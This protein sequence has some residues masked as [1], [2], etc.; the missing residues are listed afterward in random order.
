MR[1]RQ[2]LIALALPSHPLRPEHIRHVRPIV[3]PG[4]ELLPHRLAVPGP[5][6]QPEQLVQRRGVDDHPV[7]QIGLVGQV[8]HAQQL[9]AELVQLGQ[10]G[11]RRIDLVAQLAGR[12]AKD[13]GQVAFQLA[14]VALHLLDLGCDVAVDRRVERLAGQAL[15]ID[16]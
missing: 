11:T 1:N 16:P 15:V 12:T 13:L 6:A 10:E 4:L 7:V 9:G 5:L 2:T 14:Q 8:G 3:L